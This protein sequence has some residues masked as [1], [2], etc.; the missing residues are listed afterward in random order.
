MHTWRK[1][2]HTEVQA[3]VARPKSTVERGLTE[4]TFGE[5]LSGCN[6]SDRQSGAV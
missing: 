3:S 6:E 4:T 2:R 1:M 5:I